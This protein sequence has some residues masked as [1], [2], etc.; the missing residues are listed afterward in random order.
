GTR[1]PSSRARVRRRACRS[2]RGRTARRSGAS[3]P[4]SSATT[5]RTEPLINKTPVARQT[6]RDDE[7]VARTPVDVESGGKTHAVASH[8]RHSR[9]RIAERTGGGEARKA[10]E[11]LRNSRCRGLVHGRRPDVRI[12]HRNT[13]RRLASFG[14]A[15]QARIEDVDVVQFVGVRHLRNQP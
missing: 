7:Q 4:K 1:R 3:R 9:S 5:S 10:E 11:Y 15:A 14:G 6:D 12:A 8:G 2:T 13:P